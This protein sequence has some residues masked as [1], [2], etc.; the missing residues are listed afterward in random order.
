MLQQQLIRLFI[1]T[2]AV[3]FGLAVRLGATITAPP[4]LITNRAAALDAESITAAEGCYQ[5][6]DLADTCNDL[7]ADYPPEDAAG[8]EAAMFS[9]MC[10]KGKTF[11]PNVLSD[12]ASSCIDYIRSASPD[13]SSNIAQYKA[14]ETYCASAKL[15]LG[16]CKRTP[17]LATASTTTRYGKFCTSFFDIVS[18]CYGETPGFE[19]LPVSSQ[20][21]CYCYAS[22]TYYT[23][24]QPDYFGG[25]ASECASW[26]RTADPDN[27]EVYSKYATLCAS[28]G[29][30]L[31]VS[32]TYDDPSSS[33]ATVTQI[34]LGLMPPPTAAVVTATPSTS[35]SQ[36]RDH[37]ASNLYYTNGA[38]LSVIFAAFFMGFW[39]IL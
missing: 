23:T 14:L 24:W 12:A 11:V 2:A 9:C 15:S 7:I 1:L 18:A 31:S 36:G 33:A 29:D 8:A 38:W 25:F 22:D 30:I 3:R 10:C 39:L 21:K 26:V 28:Y 17:S 34:G 16:S 27:F 6:A 19:T 5:V 20:V 13:S 37:G 4:P 35:S 32:R